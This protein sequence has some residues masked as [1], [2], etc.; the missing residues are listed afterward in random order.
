M[1]P[2]LMIPWLMIPWLMIP[3]LMIL[4]VRG[5]MILMI[6]AMMILA[7]M[8]TTAMMMAM[9]SLARNGSTLTSRFVSLFYGELERDGFFLY[10]NAGHPRPFHL[11]TDGSYDLLAAGG[12]LDAMVER[13]RRFA[14]R[15][16]ARALG[17]KFH[18]ISLG[19]V[20]DDQR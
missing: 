8:M 15:S 16:V 7:M 19:G 1:I 2:Q 9:D 6:L 13:L 20:H 17:R 14:G 11:R 10:V 4:L 3:W 12:A 5:T 18:R